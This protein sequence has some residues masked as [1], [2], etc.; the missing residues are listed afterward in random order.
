MIIV[1][2]GAGFIGSNI[3]RFLNKK[4]ISNVI[5]VDDLK[6]LSQKTTL[7]EL[8]YIDLIDKNDF[9]KKLRYFDKVET[10]FHSGAC[11]NTLITDEKYMMYNN[12]YYSKVLLNHAVKNS[13][14]F[15]YAS[16]ASVYGLGVRGFYEE[17]LYESPLN[18]YAHSKHLFDNYVRKTI[19]QTKTQIVGLRYFNVYGPYEEHKKEMASVVYRFYRQAICE[20]EIKLFKG[21]S[22]F[23]RDFVF[24]DDTCDINLFFYE[25]KQLSGIFNC[26]TGKAVSFLTI[27]KQISK[28][29]NNSKIEYIPFP[30]HL[31]GKYQ[32][33]TKA[34]LMKLRTVGYNRPFL[35]IKNGIK[36]YV[37][38]MKDL[39]NKFC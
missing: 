32:T 26:G 1:T 18:I 34:E 9:I 25:N 4:G 39:T 28:L 16:S 3:I 6:T 10:I 8:R 12:Y 17:S 20:G 35:D 24:V 11:T 19:S 23:K 2:G 33:F 7:A 37:R 30:E 15:I 13:I 21:S 31:Q 22:V 5:I 27:A 36:K 29:L 38:R 14:S